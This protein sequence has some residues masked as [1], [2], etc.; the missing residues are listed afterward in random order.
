[1]SYPGDPGNKSTIFFLCESALFLSEKDRSYLGEK[2]FLTTMTALGPEF[3]DRLKS[4]GLK[5]SI[6]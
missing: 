4:R 2:G 1:M 5:L 3:I 6:N